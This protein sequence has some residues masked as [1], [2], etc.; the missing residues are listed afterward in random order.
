MDVSNSQNN[1]E[2][3]FTL[4]VLAGIGYALG[5]FLVGT[6]IPAIIL[7]IFFEAS[8]GICF[9]TCFFA[10]IGFSPIVGLVTALIVGIGGGKR[11][12]KRLSAKN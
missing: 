4:G 9:E 6:I 11:T 2:K 12:Y 8:T 1:R 5:G 7:Y 3:N 10:I